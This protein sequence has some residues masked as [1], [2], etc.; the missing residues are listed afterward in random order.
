MRRHMLLFFCA[1]LSFAG[2]GTRAHAAP[3]SV[4]SS[5]SPMAV[6]KPATAKP[7]AAKPTAAIIREARARAMVHPEGESWVDAKEGVGRIELPSGE[8]V[9]FVIDKEEGTRGN[10]WRPTTTFTVAGKIPKG[11]GDDALLLLTAKERS[12]VRETFKPALTSATEERVLEIHEAEADAYATALHR[13]MM[14][15]SRESRN[16]VTLKGLIPDLE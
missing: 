2:L 3:V 5:K 10:N 8:Q 12:Y 9:V 1:T 13:A 14:S 6:R 11:G 4:P 7:T 15:T 16:W